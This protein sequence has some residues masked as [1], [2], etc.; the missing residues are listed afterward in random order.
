MVGNRRH[1]PES[2]KQQ[3]ITMSAH[4]KSKDIAHVT[5]SSHRTVNRV[6]RLS[7]LTGSVIQKPLQAGR[8]C[9]LTSSDATASIIIWHAKLNYYSHNS[10]QYLEACVEHTPDIFL[11]E[12]QSAL[13]DARGVDVSLQTIEKTL[14]RHGFTR[15]KVQCPKTALCF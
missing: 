8:P 7:R 3:W 4:M 12:L 15:K 14:Q 10:H 13:W 11:H 9:L 6:L 2:V 5:H 1:I